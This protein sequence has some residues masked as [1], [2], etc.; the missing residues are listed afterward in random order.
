VP[1]RFKIG[2]GVAIEIRGVAIDPEG[3]NVISS[4]KHLNALIS[5]PVPEVFAWAKGTQTEARGAQAK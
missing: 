1:L 5:W 3:Q 2:E 4:D